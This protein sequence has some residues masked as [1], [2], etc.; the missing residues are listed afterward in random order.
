[1]HFKNAANFCKSHH[2][3]CIFFVLYVIAL[4]NLDYL[5]I[6]KCSWILFLSSREKIKTFLSFEERIW[7]KF[8]RRKSKL[9][10]KRR[11]LSERGKV[12]ESFFTYIS[13]FNQEHQKRELNEFSLILLPVKISLLFCYSQLKECKTSSIFAPV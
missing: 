8:E 13:H 4:P 9:S 1:M 7:E 3:K 11:K 5:A 12:S 6:L 2:L 10:R